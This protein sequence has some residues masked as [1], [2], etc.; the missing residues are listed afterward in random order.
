M[1]I[2]QEGKTMRK[3]SGTAHKMSFFFISS[4]LHLA[5]RVPLLQED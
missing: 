3:N 2:A 4:S 5:I 1:V